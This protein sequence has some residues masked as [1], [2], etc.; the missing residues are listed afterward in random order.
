M[1]L[2]IYSSCFSSIPSI[3]LYFYHFANFSLSFVSRSRRCSCTAS[4]FDC[5]I[6]RADPLRAIFLVSHQTGAFRMVTVFHPSLARQ[7]SLPHSGR[8][9]VDIRC[10]LAMIKREFN[11]SFAEWEVIAVPAPHS[12]TIITDL[13]CSTVPSCIPSH[14]SSSISRRRIAICRK[15]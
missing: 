11:Y 9:A 3:P 10:E 12:T 2:T 4:D 7:L 15:I 6:V 1:L 8:C 13:I 14:P 5:L